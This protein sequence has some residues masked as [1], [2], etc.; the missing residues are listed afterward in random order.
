[1]SFDDC[2]PAVR[3]RRFPA[4][5]RRP[6]P[7]AMNVD[8]R[9]IRHDEMHGVDSVRV[10]HVIEPSSGGSGRAVA[11]ILEAQARRGYELALVYSPRRQDEHFV[12]RI[13]LLE[14]QGRLAVFRLGMERQIRP[15]ADA[16]AFLRLR[17]IVRHCKPQVLHL[18][19]S[20][21][22][23]L[24]RLLRPTLTPPTPCVVYQPHGFSFLRNRGVFASFLRIVEAASS[25]LADLCITTS[26]GERTLASCGPI[27]WTGTMITIPNIVDCR[28]QSVHDIARVRHD[29]RLDAHAFLLCCVGNLVAEKR[30]TDIIDAVAALRA[31]GY[32]AHLLVVGDGACR[33]DIQ[34]HAA[35]KGVADAIHFLG[36]QSN[37]WVF[38]QAADVVVHAA[39]FESFGLAVAEA[40]LLAMPVV[41]AD[42]PGVREL[43]THGDSGLLY[44]PGDVAALVRS[45]RRLVEDTTL[46]H[47]LGQHARDAISGRFTAERVADAL[48]AAYARVAAGCSSS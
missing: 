13:S 38:Q 1:M 34:R 15:A 31:S 26:I 24:G 48:H 8:H 21:A 16:Q 14:Q 25:P 44:P 37:P 33:A 29:L 5:P 43:I 39:A 36:Y 46:R 11:A 32:D 45:L 30:I 2:V 22:G 41:A 35:D 28:P 27:R 6:L 42:A 17:R 47:V 19:C 7:L 9:S 3:R 23:M 4:P 10:L 12:S 40:M 18:H 20:K